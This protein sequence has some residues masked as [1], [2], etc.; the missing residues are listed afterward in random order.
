MIN[1]VFHDNNAEYLGLVEE[2]LLQEKVSSAFH[3]TNFVDNKAKYKGG[4]VAL[5]SNTTASIE[6]SNL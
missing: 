6:Y 4:V 2:S 3:G 1:S 5:T